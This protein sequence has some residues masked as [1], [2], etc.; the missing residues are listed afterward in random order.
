[1]HDPLHQRT[2][3]RTLE[4]HTHV[5][6]VET[7]RGLSAIDGSGVSLDDAIGVNRFSMMQRQHRLVVLLRHCTG[8]RT[9]RT[10]GLRRQSGGQINLSVLFPSTAR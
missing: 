1:L 9:A 6:F 4:Q 8:I 7:Q 3:V 10:N 2:H 5:P